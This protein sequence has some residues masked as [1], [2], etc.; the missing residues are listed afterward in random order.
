M[1][2]SNP[3]PSENQSIIVYRPSADIEISLNADTSHHTVWATQKQIAQIFNLDVRTISHH[4]QEFKKQRG[5]RANQGIRKFEIP[6][7][8]GV[9]EVEHY[10]M[11]VITYVGF[12]A[13]VTDSTIAFQDW[14]GEKLD[15]IVSEKQAQSLALSPLDQL[16]LTV[17]AL[18]DQQ[19]QLVALNQRVER[20]EDTYEADQGAPQMMT[21]VAYA[22][23]RGIHLSNTEISSKGKAATRYS[24]EHGYPI[25]KIAHKVWGKVNA[26][27]IDVLR[28]VFQQRS[29]FDRQ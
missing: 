10:N 11:T 6:T 23:Y 20:I 12:R 1:D 22:T 18:E 7:N 16:K 5:E 15:A 9:Q 17:A 19:K 2:K 25:E 14:V 8:G 26:Y 27:H 28:E 3:N 4:I 13:Q 29:M 24:N 21:V